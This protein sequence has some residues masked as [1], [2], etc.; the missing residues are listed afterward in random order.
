MTVTYPDQLKAAIRLADRTDPDDNIAKLLRETFDAEADYLASLIRDNPHTTK[1]TKNNATTVLDV[2]CGN[3][4]TIRN[5]C[6]CLERA[7]I[8]L[9]YIGLDKDTDLLPAEMT[10]VTHKDPTHIAILYIHGNFFETSHRFLRNYNHTYTSYNTI[11][12]VEEYKRPEFVQ[13]MADCTKT[14]GKIVNIT[15]KM[16]EPTREFLDEY[17]R[18]IHFSVLIPHHSDTL[19]TYI[20]A[21]PETGEEVRI[22]MVSTDQLIYLHERAGI[23]ENKIIP[24]EPLWVAVE[25]TKR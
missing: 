12:M 6:K 24:V 11:G 8:K 2:G 16:D 5:V 4:R 19:S 18:R 15:W 23:K 25:G 14:E 9:E 20:L 3:G 7:P 22:D 10:Q 1:D 13:K 17:Y 21:K